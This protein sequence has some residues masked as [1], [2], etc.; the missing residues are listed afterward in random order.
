MFPVPCQIFVMHTET[1]PPWLAEKPR[2]LRLHV[3]LRQTVTNNSARNLPKKR[4]RAESPE[5]GHWKEL[6][7]GF[8][9]LSVAEKET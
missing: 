4:D 6:V 2:G 8:Q 3:P 9:P 5:Q 7:A 1:R